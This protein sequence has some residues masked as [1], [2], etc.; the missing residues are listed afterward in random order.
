[1]Y[2][3]GANWDS[4][5][6]ILTPSKRVLTFQATNYYAKSVPK[7]LSNLFMSNQKQKD[8]DESRK[9]YFL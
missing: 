4:G 3:G 7:F 5:H 8:K 9:Q 6:Q 1:M 2:W